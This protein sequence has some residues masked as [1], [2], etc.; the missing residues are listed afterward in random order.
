MI[1][2]LL[3]KNKVKYTDIEKTGKENLDK[4]EKY[5]RHEAMNE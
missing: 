4:V 3:K 5:D 2:I 1:N